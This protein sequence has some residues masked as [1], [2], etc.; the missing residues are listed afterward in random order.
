M[1]IRDL[2]GT[3]ALSDALATT[4]ELLAAVLEQLKETNAERLETVASEL[5]SLG[6]KVDQ[7]VAQGG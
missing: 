1:A 4:N 3:G 2:A 6:E 7:L 5:R